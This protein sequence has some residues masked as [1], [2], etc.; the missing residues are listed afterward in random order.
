MLRKFRETLK[1]KQRGAIMV[2]FAILVPLFL[3]A[4]GLA[5]DAGFLY[6]QKAKLQDVADATALA[7]AGHLK[8]ENREDQVENAVKAF[9]GANGY[10]DKD[11]A[12]SSNFHQLADKADASSVTLEENAAWKIAYAID[13]DMLDNDAKNG[14]LR[15]H[16]RVVI[17]KRVPTF[18][19]RMLFPEQNEVVVK[20]V[21]AAEY[22]EGEEPVVSGDTPVIMVD[23]TNIESLQQYKSSNNIRLGKNFNFPIYTA[24]GNIDPTKLPGTGNLYVNEIPQHICKASYDKDKKDFVWNPPINDRRIFYFE[25]HYPAYAD[26][27][28]KDDFEKLKEAYDAERRKADAKYLEVKRKFENE[29]EAMKQDIDAYKRGDGKKRFIGWD[30]SEERMINNIKEDDKEIE[31]FMHKT[32]FDKAVDDEGTW[33]NTDK[34]SF[35]TNRQLLNVRKITSLITDNDMFIATTGITYGN[36]YCLATGYGLVVSGRKNDFNGTLYTPGKL[37]VGGEENHFLSDA[38]NSAEVSILATNVFI[39]Q[40]Y[41]IVES[42]VVADSLHFNPEGKVI[43]R[44]EGK[45]IRITMGNVVDAKNRDDWQISFGPNPSSGSGSGSSSSGSS[46]SGA[47]K[48]H[49]R[50][51][52]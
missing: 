22:V 34:K 20:A 25:H 13:T 14:E 33:G 29:A 47:A 9:A 40:W 11:E 37:Y 4:I 32:Y 15:D 19:I 5:V 2:F 41:P 28:Y 42:E 10:K 16:V 26:W 50:L 24:S 45:C 27:Q 44:Y 7:G 46:G 23:I 12:A 31:L 8:D 36:I 43:G 52:I 39:G 49:V 1:N 6:M 30:Q 21:A 38:G 51:V 48:A 17:L 3:G 18:F 35:L